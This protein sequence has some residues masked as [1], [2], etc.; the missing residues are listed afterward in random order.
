GS[1]ILDRAVTEHNLLAA[2]KLYNNI[3]FTE[4]G[5][6]LQIPGSKA[7]KIA[8][9]MITEERMKGFIDQ[10]DG[11][12]NFEAREVLPQW[13]KQIQSLCFQVNGIIEKINTAHPEWVIKVTDEQMVQ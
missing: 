1:S 6:L 4:L 2:S 13:D 7:E 9:Q 12:L 5:A 8:S 11:I 10:I 3:T